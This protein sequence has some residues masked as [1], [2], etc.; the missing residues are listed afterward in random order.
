MGA[1]MEFKCERE[2]LLDAMVAAGRAV[3]LR[4]QLPVLTGVRLDVVGDWLSVVGTDLDLSVSAD[5]M[6]EGVEDGV[7]VA[8]GRLLTDIVRSLPHGTVRL[9]T[10][11]EGDLRVESGRSKFTLRTFPDDDFPKVSTPE[12]TAVIGTDG[13]AQA[14]DQVARCASVEASR[15]ILCGVR[16]ES[17]DK[18][19]RL[20]A[21]DSYR[22]GL[23]DV[24]SPLSA[25]LSDALVPARG[26]TE[27]ARLI[28]HHKPEE[29]GVHSDSQSITFVVG[30]VTL[31]TRTIEGTFP[32]YRALIPEDH[33]FRIIVDRKE[34]LDALGRVKLV[35]DNPT[36]PVRVHIDPD[37]LILRVSTPG[38][39]D[40]E[41]HVSEFTY[42][43]DDLDLA[44]NPTYLLD[45]LEAIEDTD[46]S[47]SV[48]SALKP[49]LIRAATSDDYTYLLMPVRVE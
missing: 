26:F 45:G 20:V 30:P 21:S 2:T 38:K 17:A 42:S 1:T 16:F 19:F 46:V 39:A 35:S 31:T 3:S 32:N 27:L 4:P 29:I 9:H 44:F 43:G 7:V 28:G 13:L 25:G 41:E 11:I 14:I 23:K 37:N 22:L 49:A 47:I 34:M 10:D 33:P 24:P 12:A 40:A 5:S 36:T 18:G 8:P 6:V 15:P 48:A